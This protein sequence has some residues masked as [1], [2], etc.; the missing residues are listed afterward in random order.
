[1][2]KKI[3]N[4]GTLAFS[5][6][7]V[8][9]L[10]FIFFTIAHPVVPYDCDDWRYLGQFRRPLPEMDQWNPSR[11]LPEV[12]TPLAGIFAAF[13]VRPIVGDYL[14]SLT[15]TVGLFM[16]A[17]TAVFCLVLQRLFFRF[18][19]SK[20]VS[21]L[22]TL[23]IICLY[24]AFFKTQIDS[25][26]MLYSYNLN[27]IF[28][29]TIPNLFNSILVI[30]LMDYAAR[31]ISPDTVGIRKL[32]LLIIAFY[33][34]IFSIMFA[35]AIIAVYCFY[36]LLLS[37]IKKE[38]LKNKLYL[39]II[40]A[41]FFIYC[42]FELL[43]ERANSESGGTTNYSFFS[44]EF[45]AQLQMAFWIFV[46]LLRQIN[47]AILSFT[48]VIIFSALVLFYLNIGKDKEKPIIRCALISLA[49]FLSLFP[50]LLLVGGKAGPGYC[51]L[52]HTM[53]GIFFFYL[54]FAVIS[55]IYIITKI[56]KAAIV[57]PI[58]LV[59]LFFE[60]TNTNYPYIDQSYYS[61]DYFEHRLTPQRK[62]ALVS[63]WI[64]QIKTADRDGEGM[65]IIRIPES[66]T[67]DW[68]ISL[69]WFPEVF[70]HTLRVHGIIS[71]EIPIYLE[72]DMELTEGL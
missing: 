15:I 68:P 60:I 30:I 2:L 53:Y 13:I 31:G 19:G 48:L 20:I 28:A 9:V 14:R 12:L 24:F 49:G 44:R 71:R 8:F 10:V 17:L 4:E 65:V 64:E 66:L 47:M 37:I 69:D 40:L 25:Q 54:L 63:A 72:P 57:L 6:A 35:A 26:Y 46:G 59:L 41:G 11:I 55:M 23:T 34:A 16:A 52:T 18:S 67:P 51:S 42:G 7:A 56:K 61:T 5:I 33:F 38:N 1:M 36:E 39:I 22:S 27:T 21:I 3:R 45:F 70:S 62:E 50:A 58:F 43:G 29:Y 32:T